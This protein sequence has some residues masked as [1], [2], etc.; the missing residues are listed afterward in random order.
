MR[1]FRF[2]LEKEFKQ[3]FR[4][5]ALLPLLLVMPIAQ[6]L[7]LSFAATFEVEHIKLAV[8]DRDGGSL[9]RNLV[10]RLEA[11]SYFE[12]TYFGHATDVHGEVLQADIASV[13]L[14][15]PDHFSR[16][17]LLGRPSSLGVTVNA[18]DG[19]TAG[20]S[21]QYLQG[22]IAQFQQEQALDIRM[23]APQAPAGIEIQ[24]SSRNWYN[25][26]LNYKFFMVPGLLVLLVS[27]IGMFFTSMNIVKEKEI[28]TI[29]QLNV[30]PI[31]KAQ[32]ILGKL[33]PFWCIGMG[34]LA[35]GLLLARLIF[36]VP[37]RGPLYLIFG[38]AMIYL[39]VVLGIGLFI[40][41]VSDTQQQSMF[42]AWF[43]MII[44]VLLSGLF[45][46][47][48]NMPGWAQELTRLNP[49]RY[50]IEVTRSVLLKGAGWQ[51]VQHQFLIISLYAIVVNIGAVL[52][53]SKR[54]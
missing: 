36:A 29:E 26:T 39:L 4:D 49:V 15:I 8:V 54:S 33:I 18:I 3:I 17:L 34:I 14:E 45:T 10:G 25:S 9:A 22:V 5:R 27:M 11:S 47:I 28:G 44:F 23:N 21:V 7:V 1:T 51:S 6:L 41:T 20:V 46:P 16:D 30:T 40:S 32:F 50:F 35:F 12:L 37:M 19:M 53:Y 48:E 42:I 43:F 52:S 2:I 24:M 38:F 31:T 13:M